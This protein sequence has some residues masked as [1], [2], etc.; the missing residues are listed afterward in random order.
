MK[1]AILFSA[2]SL[3]AFAA[4]EKEFSAME[5]QSAPEI[6]LLL[7]HLFE[8]TAGDSLHFEVRISDNDQLHDWYLGLNNLSKMTKE[9]HWSQHSHSQSVV[10]DTSYYLAPS[11]SDSHFQLQLEASDHNGNK[12]SKKI[13]LFVKA[14]G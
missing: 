13:A 6:E 14:K 7:P 9:I 2:L 3:M 5:D 11:L 8:A 4:C 12:S 1:K 10:L